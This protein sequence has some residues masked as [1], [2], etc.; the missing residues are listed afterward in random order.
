MGAWGV[1][2]GD[3]RFEIW[4]LG[5]MVWGLRSG[6]F[7]VWGLGLKVCGEGFGLWAGC[8][9]VQGLEFG[10]R[11]W[12]L[13]FGILGCYRYATG[14]VHMSTVLVAYWYVL[15]YGGCSRMRTGIALRSH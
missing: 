9:G 5:F 15:K 7:G 4:D 14:T 3:G 2:V 6:V 10:F 12:C 13:G 11:G 8:V 1:G